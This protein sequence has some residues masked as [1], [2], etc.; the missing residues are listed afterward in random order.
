MS[1][2]TSVSV[3][4]TK[5]TVSANSGVKTSGSSTGSFTFVGQMTDARGH[6]IVVV[7]SSGNSD[8]S[9]CSVNS[10]SNGGIFPAGST[11]PYCIMNTSSTDTANW[12]VRARTDKDGAGT[13]ITFVSGTG[14]GGGK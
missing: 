13:G 5:P 6:L 2:V 7:Q 3:S 11:G 12:T 8:G 4:A 1:T 9:K 14:G 10:S